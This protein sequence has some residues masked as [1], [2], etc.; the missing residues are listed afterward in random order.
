MTVTTSTFFVRVRVTVLGVVAVHF[1]TSV[2]K[3]LLYELT[4]GSSYDSVQEVATGGAS[5]AIGD[6]DV[7]GSGE[8]HG[9]LSN[10]SY[11]VAV[12]RGRGTPGS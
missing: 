5:A 11:Q 9:S 12:E 2:I 3:L 4:G 6:D 8:A 1:L 7:L 10:I